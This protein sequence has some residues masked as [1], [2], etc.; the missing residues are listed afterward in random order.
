MSS[1]HLAPEILEDIVDLLHDDEQA[2]R[3]C[4]LAS[5]SWI[6]RTRKRLF[7]GI[8][9]QNKMHLKSWKDTFLDPATSPAQYTKTL[10]IKYPYHFTMQ[11]VGWIRT[12]ASVRRFKMDSSHSSETR[13][14]HISLIPL[15]AFS[16]ALESLHIVSRGMFSSRIFKLALTFPLLHSLEVNIRGFNREDYDYG[17]YDASCPPDDGSKTIPPPLILP[18]LT[19]TLKLRIRGGLMLMA[20]M[21]LSLNGNI[22]ARRLDLEC[23]GDN[24]E[25]VKWTQAILKECLP[26]VETLGVY[27]SA[28]L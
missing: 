19:G 1:R 4:C 9:F 11:D 21:I 14:T 17:W 2:L 13:D 26:T 22:R 10:S 25:D 27:L 7:A 18:V 6:E 8:E 24:P 28:T 20:P 12:F 15:Y 23:R 16:P 5:K 3:S